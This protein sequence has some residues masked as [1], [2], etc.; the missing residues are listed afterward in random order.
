MGAV[1]GDIIEITYNH[2]T[3]GSGTLFPKSGEDNTYFP[4]GVTTGSDENMIDGS[5][6]PIWV[7]NRRRGFFEAVCSNDQNINQ[8]LD[9]MIALSGD[10]TPADW[11]FSIINGTVWGGKGKPVGDFEGNIN[12]ATFTL[13]V[14]G[15][16]FQKIVG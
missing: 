12:Q 15:G 9:K 11:T 2:P 8:E 7:K 1:G 3:L 6:N 13:R 14:E 4:G 16:K 10:P 5:G